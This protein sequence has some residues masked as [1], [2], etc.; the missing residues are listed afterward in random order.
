MKILKCNECGA[1]FEVVLEPKNGHIP[2]GFRELKA[3]ETDGAMEKH[4]PVVEQDGHKLIVKVGSVPHPMT[5]EHY[6]NAVWVEFEDGSYEKKVLT[7][8]ME[9]QVH[10]CM[11]GKSGKVTVYEYCNLHGLW[12]TEYT[13]KEE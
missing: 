1:V 6:I 8:E 3:G 10:F 4:V 2:E 7:P 11:K 9:P 13:L 12:K 5:P